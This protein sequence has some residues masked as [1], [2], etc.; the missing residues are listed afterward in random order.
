MCET[1]QEQSM[2]ISW[3]N[4]S[5]CSRCTGQGLIFESVTS[6]VVT[7]DCR[8]ER[9]GRESTAVSSKGIQCWTSYITHLLNMK[10]EAYVDG[11]FKRVAPRVTVKKYVVHFIPLCRA[12]SKLFIHFVWK[13]KKLKGINFW[14]WPTSQWLTH[15][16]EINCWK[17]IFIRVSFLQRL[18]IQNCTALSLQRKSWLVSSPF[19]IFSV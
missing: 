15:S 1:E 12:M 2:C 11:I 18:S 6:P 9:V 13:E 3:V 19:K 10:E 16:F 7:N 17:I 4:C 8:A 5:K 14:Q